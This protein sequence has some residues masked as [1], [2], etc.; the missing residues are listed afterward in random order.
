MEVCF[1]CRRPI[2]QTEVCRRV[3]PVSYS[4]EVTV[5]MYPGAG[6]FT[7]YAPV[8][9]CTTCNAEEEEREQKRLRPGLVLKILL[10]LLLV[11]LV[12]TVAMGLFT[13]F[14]NGAWI[15]GSIGIAALLGWGVYKI[16]QKRSRK[17]EIVSTG[18]QHH[19]QQQDILPS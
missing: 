9:L 16:L 11:S 1:I 18:G 4:R 15:R 13:L 10:T 7:H 8:S 6:F 14:T 17:V 5:T 19:G 3:M 12:Y 2:S